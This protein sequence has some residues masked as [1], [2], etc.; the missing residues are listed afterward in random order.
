MIDKD[1]STYSWFT[2]AWVVGLSSWAGVV[3]FYR[4]MNNGEVKIFNITQFIGEIVTSGLVG[5]I[6]FFLCEYAGF[7]QLLTA[8]LVGISGHMGSRA[9]MLMEKVAESKYGIK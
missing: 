1:P 8:A 7:S 5:V 2:Y 9:I 6:T 4:K 3:S